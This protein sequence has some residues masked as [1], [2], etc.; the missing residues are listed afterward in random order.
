VAA[1]G[2]LGAILVVVGAAQPASPFTSK[3][4]GS[5]FF[6]VGSGPSLAP[7]ADG[8]FL[9]IVTLYAGV[10]LM[11]GAW[12]H[13][14]IRVRARPHT[15]IRPL[16]AVLAAWAAPLLVGPPL[17]SRDVYAYAAQGQLVSQGINPY[18]RGPD[19][20]GHGPFLSLVDPLWRHVIAPYGALWERL[21]QLVVHLGG[22]RVVASVVGFRVLALVGVALIAWAVP[23]MARA[24]HSSAALAFVL[25]VL[26]PL[27][28]LDL[29]GGA[30]NDALMLGM[31]AAACALALT[32][33]FGFALALCALGATIK[34][35]ALIGAAFIG[36]W[37]AASVPGRRRIVGAALGVAAAAAAVVTTGVLSG[38]GWQWTGGLAN[39]GVVVS[40]LD[41]ATALGLLL[42]HGAHLLGMA[43]HSAGIVH[44]T[45]VA[46]LA[47]AAVASVRLLAGTG[48]LGAA[49]ALGWSLLA[50]AVLGPVV[51]PW[52]ESW[53][54]VFLAV[55]ARPFVV[56]LILVLSAAA[57]VAA[58]PPAHLLVDAQPLL[59]TSC[60]VALVGAAAAFVVI[61]VAPAVTA[62]GS[63]RPAISATSQVA[64]AVGRN[65]PVA[66]EPGR[67]ASSGS[68]TRS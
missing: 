21:A 15:P 56:R 60:W 13:L 32:G 1:C 33:R 38:L 53:G 41:P 6:G 34:L 45:R 8:R 29:L 18:G 11:V 20:L 58:V 35:P 5:W 67:L 40:W 30:H 25:A 36:A 19:A 57:C 55:A 2:A 27:V 26:N 16:V 52:Y 66:S 14:V 9:G 42:A 61:R 49:A 46:A 51:W 54:F 24:E 22:H 37:W 39:P 17:F 50:F 68:Q 28:L 3:L 65:R 62:A 63:A 4:P 64:P 23:A 47:A 59:V 10:M 31:L 43:G 7:G 12:F 44:A 48:R